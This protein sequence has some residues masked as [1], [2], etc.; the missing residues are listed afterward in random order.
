VLDAICRELKDFSKSTLAT[1]TEA[2][3]FHRLFD[4]ADAGDAL[5]Q[6]VLDRCIGVWSA[7]AVTLIHAYDPQ[8]IVFGGGVM[9]RH[10]AILPRI[11]EHVSRHAWAE[12]GSVKIVAGGAGVLCRAAGSVAAAAE[13]SMMRGSNYDKLP[14]IP[15]SDDDSACR[16]GWA[17]LRRS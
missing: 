7:L 4:A 8:I 13:A 12:P 6:E 14:A 3:D 9:R 16:I 1:A 2:I 15:V 10:E 5:A 17:Q 11:R